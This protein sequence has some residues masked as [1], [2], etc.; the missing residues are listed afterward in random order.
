[1]RI[2]YVSAAMFTIDA[3]RVETAS[4]TIR[5]LSVILIPGDSVTKQRERRLGA[6]V[7]GDVTT[8]QGPEHDGAVSQASEVLEMRE[9]ESS[10]VQQAASS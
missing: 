3:D 8:A 10:D 5:E 6:D 1:M 7:P 2:P 9:L 4:M